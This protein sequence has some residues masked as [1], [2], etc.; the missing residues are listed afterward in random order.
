MADA[1]AAH[2]LDVVGLGRRPMIADP[3]TPAK[4]LSGEMRK[5]PTPEESVHLLHL[6]PWFSAQLVRLGTGLDPD[7]SLSGEAAAAHFRETEVRAVQ[8][9]AS[10]TVA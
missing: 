3:R 10:V 5:A 2:E 4:L 7:L 6:I 9:R 1:I 8:A